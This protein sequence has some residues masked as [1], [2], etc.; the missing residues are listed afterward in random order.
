MEVLVNFGIGLLGILFLTL[1]NA[2][3]YLAKKD[4]TFSWP[5]HVKENYNRWIW[6]G[7]MIGVISV[8]VFVEPNTADG[9]KSFTGL[10]VAG[11]RVSFFTLGLALTAMTKKKSIN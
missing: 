6:A 2:K 5:V 3:D 10:D 1:F 11:S 8:I 9:I 7:L 4:K